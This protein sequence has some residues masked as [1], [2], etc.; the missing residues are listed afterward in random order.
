MERLTVSRKSVLLY[1]LLPP[2]MTADVRKIVQGLVTLPFHGPIYEIFC[3]TPLR[4]P[5]NDI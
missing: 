3:T 1:V 4:Y 5:F 2:V